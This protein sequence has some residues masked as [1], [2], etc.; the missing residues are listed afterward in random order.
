MEYEAAVLL[1]SILWLVALVMLNRKGRLKNPPSLW[2]RALVVVLIALS[3][4]FL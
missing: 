1:G 4:L 3:P 2:M